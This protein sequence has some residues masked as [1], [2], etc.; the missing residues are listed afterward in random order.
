MQVWP[1]RDVPDS[2]QGMVD[3]SGNRLTED[4]DLTSAWPKQAEQQP[5]RR[6]FAGAIGSQEAINR[7]RGYPDAELVQR[8][9]FSRPVGEIR[10]FDGFSHST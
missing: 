10:G 7:A 2:P 9:C 3:P 1:F 6:G 5:D 8:E 4:A